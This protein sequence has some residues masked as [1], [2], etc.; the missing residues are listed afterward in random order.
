MR[1]SGWISGLNLLVQVIGIISG[2]YLMASESLGK[3]ALLLV[4]V[5]GGHYGFTALS[6]ILMF[7]H[8][9]TMGQD[10]LR[11]L[12]FAVRYGDGPGS[13]PLAW[14]IIAWVCGL[15]YLNIASY[16]IWFLLT[17]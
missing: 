5:V 1:G 15:L 7:L 4:I 17:R 2:I 11:E 6:N 3:G 10:E 8:Q 9:R 13:V 12:A 14:K 16:S